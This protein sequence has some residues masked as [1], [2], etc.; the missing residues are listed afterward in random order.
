MRSFNEYPKYTWIEDWSVK[1][2]TLHEPIPYSH[3][4][5][6]LLGSTGV[7][8]IENEQPISLLLDME[9]SDQIIHL[10]DS[11][12][13]KSPNNKSSIEIIILNNG[14][15][16]GRISGREAP[17]ITGKIKFIPIL[18]ISLALN[19]LTINIDLS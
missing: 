9:I 2:M 18:K 4:I 15:L 7:L 19:F 5:K 14:V 11:L 16:F 1:G 17:K 13:V 3:E 8:I 6:I 12:F 10:C